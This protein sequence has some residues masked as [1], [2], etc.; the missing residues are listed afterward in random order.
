MYNNPQI[1]VTSENIG[2]TGIAKRG[3]VC[4]I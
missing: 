2:N 3:R 1:I 4:E